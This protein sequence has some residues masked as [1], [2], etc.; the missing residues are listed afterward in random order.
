M[1]EVTQILAAIEQGDPH[2]AAHL[3]P[4]VYEEFR[5]QAAQSFTSLQQTIASR[6]E[7]GRQSIL[8][9]A[10]NVEPV[11]ACKRTEASA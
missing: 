2:A 5:R 11:C 8:A 10:V 3:L 4:L 1:S 9:R 7:G 6:G